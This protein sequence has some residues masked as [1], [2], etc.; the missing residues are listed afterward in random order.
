[1]TPD[2][3]LDAWFRSATAE[4]MRLCPEYHAADP[5]PKRRE[6]VLRLMC[7]ACGVTPASLEKHIQS[8]HPGAVL[9]RPE[10]VDFPVDR[11]REE[12]S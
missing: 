11:G 9:P 2:D 10:P 1:M 12:A 3:E 5:I 8:R 6:P 7:P 4:T